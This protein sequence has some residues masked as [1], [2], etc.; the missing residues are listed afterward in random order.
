MT[1][2]GVLPL[3]THTVGLERPLRVQW[4][5]DHRTLTAELDPWGPAGAHDPWLG[6]PHP[7]NDGDLL[8]ELEI[9]ARY[10]DGRREHK[11]TATIRGR[12]NGNWCPSPGCTEHMR[13]PSLTVTVMPGDEVPVEA[14]ICVRTLRGVLTAGL[15]VR[16]S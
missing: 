15:D 13:R 7:F 12:P 9:S 5:H 16:T 2:S 6:V 4:P 3:I 1:S 11:A 8:I 14:E 10:A